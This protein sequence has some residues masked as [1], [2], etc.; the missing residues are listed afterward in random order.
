MM[1]ASLARAAVF[2]GAA[3]CLSLPALAQEPSP[4]L[5]RFYLRLSSGPRALS[6][7]TGC[8][9]NQHPD[10]AHIMFDSEPGSSAYQQAQEKF[11]ANG[12]NCLFR[13]YDLRATNLMAMGAIAEHLIREEKPAKPVRPRAIVEF[14]GGGTFKW[15]WRNLPP[16]IA[17]QS[18]PLAECLLARYGDKVE[19][20]LD[21]R[22]TSAGERNAFNAMLAQISDCIPAGEQRT[23]QPQI[24]RAALA[25]TYYRA[26]RAAARSSGVT[27]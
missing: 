3:I 4:E 24:L 6:R 10:E 22:Q 11:F 23:L 13:P 2:A 8:L 14:N 18:L 19:A 1:P 25:T 20:V 16:A 5:D 27:G 26:A 12:G 15:D 21:A 9:L 17:Q 7:M